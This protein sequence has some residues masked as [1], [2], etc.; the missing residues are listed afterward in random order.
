MYGID[1]RI[2]RLKSRRQDNWNDSLRTQSYQESFEKRTNQRATKYAL[3]ALQE[4]DARSTDISYEEFQKVKEAL[5]K[6]MPQRGFNPEFRMQGSVPLNIH[7]RGV[8]DVDILEIN[9]ALI[10]YSPTGAKANTYIPSGSVSTAADEVLKMRTITEDELT[11]QYYGAKVDKGNAKSI[12]LSEG[13]FRRKV[14]VVPSHWFDSVDYQE[15]GFEIHRGITVVDKNTRESFRNFPFLFGHKIN[16]KGK[17]TNDGS[18][19]AT[20]LLKNIK[21]DSE[22]DNALSSYDIASL[23]FHCPSST[24]VSRSGRDLAVLS[25]TETWLSELANNMQSA[26]ML[27]APDRTRKIIDSV[28]KWHGLVTLSK[29]TTALAREVSNE[30]LGS[31]YLI[32]RDMPTIRRHLAETAV[33][34]S[35]SYW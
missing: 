34:T 29:D 19:M 13:G 12:Q 2:A 32:D 23:M 22:Y 21:S 14:D 20:R 9:G 8:S 3:G 33:P 4:V 30:T 24:I 27:D 11:K 5:E 7:I 31:F 6:R 15:H 10:T 26:M 35:Q 18:K 16:S 1:D 25:G 17:E 28:E